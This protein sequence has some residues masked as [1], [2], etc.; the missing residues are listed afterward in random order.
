MGLTAF[1]QQQVSTVYKQIGAAV[2]APAGSPYWTT[3][4]TAMAA[5]RSAVVKKI[6]GP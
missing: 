2:P 3:D 5:I 6:V 1:V 4:E